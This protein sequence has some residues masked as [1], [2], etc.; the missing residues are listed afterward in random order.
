MALNKSEIE[1]TVNEY[2]DDIYKFCISRVE[3]IESAKDITQDVFL[4]FM[5]SSKKLDNVNLR[6]WL[7]K[8]ARIK[9]QEYYRILK[10]EEG[11]KSFTECDNI[12][13]ENVKAFDIR[14]EEFDALLTDAQKRILSIL[15]E[16]EKS[17]FVKLFIEKKTIRIISEETGLTENNI[18]VKSHRIKKKA[19]KVISTMDLLINV[20]LFKLFS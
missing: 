10:T 5:Q 13:Q 3:N 17:L 18:Y 1:K 16:D 6:A 14:E 19:K 11:F 4:I 2:Y 9:I 8:T 7:Y 12:P 20:I 15:N